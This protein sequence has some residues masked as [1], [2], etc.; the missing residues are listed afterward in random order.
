V[1][2]ADTARWF[3]VLQRTH[4]A[5]LLEILLGRLGSPSVLVVDCATIESPSVLFMFKN[6]AALFALALDVCLLD[7]GWMPAYQS[8]ICSGTRKAYSRAFSLFQREADKIFGLHS[9]LS[10]SL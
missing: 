4:I 10:E 2:H 3:G 9:T 1:L 6:L 7:N 8:L 5:L